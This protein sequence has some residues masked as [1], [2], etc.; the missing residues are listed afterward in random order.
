MYSYYKEFA[1]LGNQAER[2][3]DRLFASYSKAYPDEAAQIT[4]RNEG[5]FPD[6]WDK[7][8][9]SYSPTDP[10]VATRKL[11]EAVLNKIAPVLP[12]M[13]G[14]SADLTGS[15]LTRWKGA[16]DFQNVSLFDSHR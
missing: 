9:P 7:L 2:E 14:G 3:W 11:S 15:N 1:D 12:E 13:I 6:N 5:R 10:A 16:V 4:R 8:L